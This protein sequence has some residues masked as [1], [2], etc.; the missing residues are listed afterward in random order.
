MK[1]VTMREALRRSE[2]FGDV[3]AGDSWANWRVLLIAIA[4]EELAEAEAVA[5]KALSGR[6]GMPIEAA[7]EFWAIVGRRGGKSRSMAVLAAWLAACKDYRSIL[8]PGERGQLQVLS[9]TRDQA[10]NLFNFIVGIFEGSRALRG[11]VESKTADTLC[12]KCHID[13]VVRPAS[14]RS[15]R[16]ST[17]VGVLCDEIS[18]WRSEDSSNPDT[19]I[20]RAL[21]PSLM[22]TGG[23][24]VAISSPYSRHGELWKAYRKH[25]GKD[26]SLSL[27]VKAAS[28]IMNPSL[29][30]AFIDAQYEDDP[31]S[32]AAEYGAEFR[33]DIAAF[34]DRDIVEG[35]IDRG[36]YE[37]LRRAGQQYVCFIDSAGGSGS[38]SFTA[39]IAHSEGNVAILDAIRE[40]RPPFSPKSVVEEIAQWMKSYGVSRAQ[41]DKWGGDFP[42][43]EFAVHLVNV[44][45]SAK[46]KSDLYRD[47]LP[48]LNSGKCRLL[49]NSR[50]VS[51]LCGLERRT[52]RGGRDSIDHGPGSHDDIANAVCGALLLAGGA[53]PL[54]ITDAVLTW[55]AQPAAAMQRQFTS[56]EGRFN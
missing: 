39:A 33:S 1:L 51:Q 47:A 28:E 38:D 26:D 20:V 14:F 2:Y 16:G 6:A 15:T 46:P 22:T 29:D 8:A 40:Y 48:V 12:L 32:A 54:V 9:A 30:R 3:L 23:P 55:S 13:I 7:R 31:I 50:L 37:R 5:F 21:R 49:D 25:F 41:S 42:I 4:G 52:A 53:K 10:G 35:C 27:V 43:E 45:A 34:I 44:E 36:V 11:L 17:C 24:L 18:F 19:E 56:F